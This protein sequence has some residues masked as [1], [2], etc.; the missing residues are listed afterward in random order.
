MLAVVNLFAQFA[1]L[2]GVVVYDVAA[3]A[4]GGG[5]AYIIAWLFLNDASP[6]NCSKG[7]EAGKIVGLYVAVVGVHGAN[8]GNLIIHVNPL[9]LNPAMCN[10]LDD[11]IIIMPI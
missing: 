8:V 1:A 2:V 11:A 3:V 5:F 6:A 9:P 7:D 4:G 10:I